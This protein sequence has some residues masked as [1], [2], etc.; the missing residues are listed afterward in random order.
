[1]DHDAHGF[2]FRP[3]LK[4]RTLI[5]VCQRWRYIV[6]AS[7]LRLDLQLLCT[8]GTPVRKNLDVWPPLPLMIDYYTYWDADDGKSPTL[9]E[10]EDVIAALNH[11]DR[12][13][14][15]GISVTGSLLEKMAMTM[16]E[17]F[18]AL[19]HLWLSSKDGNVPVLS[20]T[21]FGGSTPRLRIAHLEGIPFPALPTLLLTATDLVDLQLLNIPKTG[22]V[23]PD[24]M[25]TGLAALTRLEILSI[26][27]QSPTPRPGPRFPPLI[28]VVF[29]S[30]IAFN[31]RGVSEYLEDLVA[32]IDTPLF[33]NFTI[34][35]FNQLKFEIPRCSEFIHRTES[36]EIARF[37]HARVEFGEKHVCVSLHEGQVEVEPLESLE[38]RFALQISCQSLD[39]QLAHIAQILH[40]F[41][42][43]L[44]H[45]DD[46]SIDTRDLHPG[47][48]A[49]LHVEPDEWRRLLCPFMRVA[50][51]RVSRLL[52]G[53]V[54]LALED[55]PQRIVADL[56][57]ALHSL[58]LE[59]QPEA[60]VER[61]IG[62]RQKSG[63]PVNMTGTIKPG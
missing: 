63:R 2:P 38:S 5:H 40:H 26:G 32:R 54:A 24:A 30:L 11:S 20:E 10:E 48:R 13:R 50:T 21:F 25:V 52:A 33:K 44:S 36:L 51:L 49:D 19:T 7:P 35:C 46:L 43:V 39:W 56:L 31:F 55:I 12:V 22:Y 29:P 61:Y 16:Q 28:R 42:A 34:V 18:P 15:V 8:H 14:Y 57:P 17:P 59:D 37:K 23:P 58:C 3:V 1:M 9:S 53:Q 4:W 41:P 47:W 45:V 6:F 60:S 27:F 62:A